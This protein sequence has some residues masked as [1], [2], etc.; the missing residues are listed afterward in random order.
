[1]ELGIE[2]SSAVTPRDLGDSAEYRPAIPPPGG[3]GGDAVSSSHAEGQMPLSEEARL[4]RSHQVGDGRW[5]GTTIA[6]QAWCFR[7]P[8]AERLE[9]RGSLWLWAFC[10]WLGSASL[11]PSGLCAQSLSHQRRAEGCALEAA[12][13]MS[14]WT[15]R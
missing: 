9:S 6:L 12:C 5:P 11:R 14:K 13:T 15:G 1:M 10:S 4:A 3:P 8:G 2:P 7:T